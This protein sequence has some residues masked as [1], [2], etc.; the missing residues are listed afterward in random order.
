M[1]ASCIVINVSRVSWA[2]KR[3]FPGSLGLP[4]FEALTQHLKD[5]CA[6]S[7]APYL[8]RISTTS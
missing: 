6:Y 7:R 4:S 2:M 1:I 8:T 5:T 3:F